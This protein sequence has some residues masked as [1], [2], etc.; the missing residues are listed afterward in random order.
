VVTLSL[1]Q[2]LKAALGGSKS[3]PRFRSDGRCGP[4]FP[5]AGAPT[6]GECDPTGNADKVGPCCRVDSGWCGNVRFETWGHCPLRPGEQTT[7]GSVGCQAGTCLDFSVIQR[8]REAAVERF[9]SNS[10][11]HLQGQSHSQLQSA[12]ARP[13]AQLVPAAATDARGIVGLTRFRA[14]GRCGPNYGAPGAPSFGECDPTADSDQRGPCCRPD[15]GWCKSCR[16]AS[17]SGK[18]SFPFW[19][20]KRGGNVCRERT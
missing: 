1:P 10:A 4:D 18:P 14:D 5:A 17:R 7:D 6:F 13:R 2:I 8:Q 9:A 19:P 11:S 12:V 15:S 3:E 16:A 20:A